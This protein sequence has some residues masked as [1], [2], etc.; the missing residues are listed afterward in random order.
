MGYSMNV[1]CRKE[2]TCRTRSLGFLSNSNGLLDT[3]S[4]FLVAA[5]LIFNLLLFLADSPPF[6]RMPVVVLKWHSAEK[7]RIGQKQQIG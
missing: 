2:P 6:D 1:R 7:E 5:H 3:G 4:F